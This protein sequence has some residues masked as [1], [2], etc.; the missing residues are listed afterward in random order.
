[1]VTYFEQV[2]FRFFML[3]EDVEALSY[4]TRQNGVFPNILLPS[5]FNIIYLRCIVPY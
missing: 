1:M 4:F 2:T 3:V 5:S